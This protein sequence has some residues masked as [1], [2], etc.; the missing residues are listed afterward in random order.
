[1]S[2]GRGTSMGGLLPGE[3]PYHAISHG[4][5][6]MSLPLRLRAESDMAQPTPIF[7]PPEIRQMIWAL[8]LELE[9]AERPLILLSQRGCIIPTKGIQASVMFRVSRETRHM[10]KQVY[11]LSLPVFKQRT[12]QRG[13]CLLRRMAHLRGSVKL[14]PARDIFYLGR[15]EAF[16]KFMMRMT[17]ASQR[18][19]SE[20]TIGAFIDSHNDLLH[21]YRLLFCDV[22]E[23]DGIPQISAISYEGPYETCP[24]LDFYMYSTAT[25]NGPIFR[26]IKYAFE[27]DAFHLNSRKYL[28]PYGRARTAYR[29]T[30]LDVYQRSRCKGHDFSGLVRCFG[31][32][33]EVRRFKTL[34]SQSIKEAINMGAQEFLAKYQKKISVRDRQ[35]AS[36]SEETGDRP[37]QEVIDGR[38]ASEGAILSFMPKSLFADG[39]ALKKYRLSQTDRGMYE[40]DKGEQ[41]TVGE[42]Q[43]KR[44]R[45]NEQ[46]K[47]QTGRRRKTVEQKKN[48]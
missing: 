2:P 10:A 5:L 11:T 46:K 18:G 8:F 31:L 20:D 36:T 43:K 41:A 27:M 29:V 13:L 38:S 47:E 24:A 22:F 16:T 30:E 19:M 23:P 3:E 33:E 32:D 9:A 42:A 6:Q 39:S 21:P 14:N 4:G 37:W 7:V 44:R 48:R 40:D 12:E 26:K 45:T 1:M 15:H 25:L 34:T 35:S 17:P 28:N